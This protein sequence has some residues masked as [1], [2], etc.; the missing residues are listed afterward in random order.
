MYSQGIY[1]CYLFFS[2]VQYLS[3]NEEPADLALSP[4]VLFLPLF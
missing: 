1:L 4:L 3:E 2:G